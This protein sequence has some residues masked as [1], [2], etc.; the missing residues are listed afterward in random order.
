MMVSVCGKGQ[1]ETKFNLDISY[2][3]FFF[4]AYWI[5]NYTWTEPKF[6]EIY[7]IYSLKIVCGLH[8]IY[9]DY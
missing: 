9:Y 6:T 2:N 7:N 4:F 5:E 8:V 3:F 1:L